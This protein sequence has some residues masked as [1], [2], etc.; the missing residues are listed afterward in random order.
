MRTRSC[1]G[2]LGGNQSTETVLSIADGEA[3][4]PGLDF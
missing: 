1:F 2:T 4:K 3:L